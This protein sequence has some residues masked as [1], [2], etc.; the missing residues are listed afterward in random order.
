M[1]VPVKRFVLFAREP[2]SGQV[3]TRLAR[4]VGSPAPGDHGAHRRR[5]QGGRAPFLPRAS[6]A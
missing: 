1:N 6:T 2:V 4:E 5:A 3:K